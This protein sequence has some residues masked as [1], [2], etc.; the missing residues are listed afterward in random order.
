MEVTYLEH[1]GDIVPSRVRQ[2]VKREDAA[3]V[4]NA[5]FADLSI[6]WAGGGMI[7]TAPD[8]VRFAL[9]LDAET[10]L[11]SDVHAR[12]TTPYQLADGT[13]SEYALGWRI[14]TDGMGTWVA[15]S[16]GATGG[17]T[18]LLRLPERGAA[19]A[20]FSNVQNAEG[21]AEAARRLAE[22]ALEHTPEP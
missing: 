8:L 4:L 15:H 7:S 1:Q 6:K 22:A 19:V 20:V 2:Y 16:G 13:M 5:P 14:S 21:L 18:R 11:P 9:A 10:I 12:M 3:G 17:S